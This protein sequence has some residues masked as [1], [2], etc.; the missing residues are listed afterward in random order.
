MAGIYLAAIVPSAA[1]WV[2]GSRFHAVATVASCRGLQLAS[3]INL[4][5][6]SLTV[7]AVGAML[8]RALSDTLSSESDVAFALVAVGLFELLW[9]VS[10]KSQWR[11]LHFTDGDRL[12]GVHAIVF[13]GLLWLQRMVD[14]GANEETVKDVERQV[15]MV[16]ATLLGGCCLVFAL[17]CFAFIRYSR[18]NVSAEGV[19]GTRVA[20]HGH[21]T[22]AA[23]G[24]ATKVVP[25]QTSAW[26]GAYFYACVSAVVALLEYPFLWRVL[27]QEPFSW[28]LDLVW[29]S[30]TNM[31]LVTW[32]AAASLFLITQVPTLAERQSDDAVEAPNGEQNS[33]AAK[34]T[35]GRQRSSS[36]PTPGRIFTQRQWNLIVRKAFHIG[37]VVMFLPAVVLGWQSTLL[38]CVATAVAAKVMILLEFARALRVFPRWLWLGVHR[39]MTKYTDTRDSGCFILCHIYLLLGC[40]L[41]LWLTLA[42]AVDGR[43]QLLVQPG[44]DSGELHPSALLLLLSGVLAVGVGDAVAACVGIGSKAKGRAITWGTVLEPAWRLWVLET[45]PTDD[46]EDDQ[47]EGAARQ[48]TRSPDKVDDGTRQRSASAAADAADSKQETPRAP[49]PG[50]GQSAQI[51]AAAMMPEFPGSS[52][53]IQGTAAFVVSLVVT[54][55]AAH[56]LAHV[57]GSAAFLASLLYWSSLVSIA[58]L[59]ALLETFCPIADNVAVPLLLWMAAA[60][61]HWYGLRTGSFR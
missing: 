15:H 41:P 22:G 35:T 43:F 10:D 60:G 38:L 25:S 4:S 40:A 50:D 45:T 46:D 36:I 29:S 33:N 56:L 18:R 2:S 6:A 7:S 49:A 59:A 54:A 20:E 57:L 52:K 26:V 39:H 12:L 17:L 32:W 42:G 13:G 53:T 1:L 55:A 9:R 19:D 44:S 51:D 30:R 8:V 48:Q 37:A 21:G 27:G 16:V 5:S 61:L 23:K 31:A 58:S 14:F 28:V 11:A 3:G 47:G 24:G 34:R